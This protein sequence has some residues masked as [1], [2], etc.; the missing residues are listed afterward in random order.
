MFTKEIPQ[1]LHALKACE[2]FI[3]CELKFDAKKQDKLLKLP[4]NP[5]TFHKHNPHDPEIWLSYGAAV[6]KLIGYEKNY[7]IGF[8]LTENDPFFCLDIDGCLIGKALNPLYCDIVDKL[9]PCAIEIS[10]SG[11]GLHVWGKYKNILKHITDSTIK[12]NHKSLELYSAKQFIFLT[13]DIWLNH[14]GT[15]DYDATQAINALITSHFTKTESVNEI[16]AWSDEPHP[17]WDGYSDDE[18]LIAAAL[19]SRSAKNIFAGKLNFSELWT[20]NVEAIAREFPAMKSTEDYDASR[21]DAALAQHLAFWCGNDCG[22]MLRLMNMSGLKRE[23]WEREDYLQRTILNAVNRQTQFHSKK[24]V[25]KITTNLVHTDAMR[26]FMPENTFK[27][28]EGVKEKWKDYIY[29]EDIDQVLKP[30][31]TFITPKVFRNTEG[32]YCF[33]ITPSYFE[34]KK[35]K[36]TT[37]AWLAYSES[38]CF[39]PTRVHTTCFFPKFGFQDILQVN[40]LPAVNTWLPPNVRRKKGSAAIFEDLIHTM[41]PVERDS[42]IL[43]SYFAALVQYPGVKFDWTVYLQSVQG[44]GKN[45]LI[46]F[47]IYAIGQEYVYEARPKQLSNKFNRWLIGKLLICVNEINAAVDPE[48]YEIIKN[49]ITSK[50]QEIEGKNKDQINKNICCNFIFTGNHKDGLPQHENERRFAIFFAAQQSKAELIKDGLTLEYF[51]KIYRFRDREDGLAIV[52]D[53]L[54]CYSIPDEFNPATK[55]RR[56]PY[57]SST[58]EAIMF[59][60]PAVE[61]EIFEVIQQGQVGFKGGWVSGNYLDNL[62]RRLGYNKLSYAHRNQAVLNLG[63]VRHPKLKD[64]RVQ[65]TVSPDGNRTRLYCLKDHKTINWDDVDAVLDSYTQAQIS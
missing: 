38:Q 61:Q 39:H 63:Y 16:Q 58:T 4:L 21:A 56:A 36:T 42:K 62:L 18:E 53:F 30:N 8:V 6:E 45:T 37:N 57:T 65:R 14:E 7:G 44:T 60:K 31:N 51:D 55:A 52:A 17:D 29:I 59:N 13:G 9:E 50:T 27:D 41:F 28:A 22:R 25:S 11:Q 32:G 47:L 23:K 49:L 40:G 5:I 48:T 26:D 54:H 12:I 1:Q 46:E 10:Q 2:Q 64:G 35:M 43:L 20:C 15:C 19:R 24:G 3:I 34:A 33:Q